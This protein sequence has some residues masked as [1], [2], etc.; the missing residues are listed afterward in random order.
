MMGKLNSDKF[1]TEGN[2]P[3]QSIRSKQTQVLSVDENAEIIVRS[4]G[5]KQL[6]ELIMQIKYLQMQ[7][8]LLQEKLN[9]KQVENTSLEDKM[10][11]YSD[12]IQHEKLKVEHKELQ[13]KEM[14]REVDT[15]KEGFQFSL[16]K[17]IAELDKYM[18]ERDNFE[19]QVKDLRLEC[20]R[21][22]KQIEELR[23]RN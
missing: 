22:D 5:E 9:T 1:L 18:H 6:E 23:R 14:Q 2:S 15:A 19:S 11:Y 4:A 20:V 12:M 7:N 17:I 8:Q 13:M 16:N 10:M 3:T 21:K